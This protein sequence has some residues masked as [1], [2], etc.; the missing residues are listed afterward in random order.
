M[1]LLI[2]KWS[3]AK[4]KAQVKLD[5][6]KQNQVALQA[7]LKGAKERE[8]HLELQIKELKSLLLEG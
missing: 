1:S 8:A 3:G 2:E 4:E 7:G 6:Y 5:K